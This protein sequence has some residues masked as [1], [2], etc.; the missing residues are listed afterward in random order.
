MTCD[1][2]PGHGQCPKHS[3]RAGV[4]YR[5]EHRGRC[6]ASVPTQSAKH[7]EHNDWYRSEPSKYDYSA[8]KLHMRVS[9]EQIP[10][11]HPDQVG[12]RVGVGL[13]E[14]EVPE[15]AARALMAPNL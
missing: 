5:D 2:D 15:E 12:R 8:R 9:E 3:E 13:N 10:G 4:E 14:D 7:F 1:G 11:Q 6:L